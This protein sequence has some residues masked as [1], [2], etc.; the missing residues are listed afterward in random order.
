MKTPTKHEFQVTN[1][2]CEENS[3]GTIREQEDVVFQVTI[4]INSDEYGW[5]EFYDVESG[6]GEWYSE[7]GIWIDNMTITDYDGIFALPQFITDKLSELGYNV[8]NVT[9]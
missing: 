1:Y 6:G 5:F 9:L 8:E 2:V 3:F 4:G 7:G